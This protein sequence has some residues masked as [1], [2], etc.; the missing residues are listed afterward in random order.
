[1]I[2]VCILVLGAI[3]APVFGVSVPEEGWKHIGMA[4]TGIFGLITG[5]VTGAAWVKMQ[6]AKK[7]LADLDNKTNQ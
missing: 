3:Y 2:A 1:M 7:K 4:I 6:H 5:A